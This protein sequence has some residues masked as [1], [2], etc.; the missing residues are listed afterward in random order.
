MRSCNLALWLNPEKIE[1]IDY[2]HRTD[3]CKVDR[4]TL[5]A[6]LPGLYAQLIVWDLGVL[7]DGDLSMES[8]SVL[9]TRAS[10]TFL[11]GDPPS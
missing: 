1:I 7:L 6:S 3:A 8:T 11:N 4:E 10:Q 2:G 5:M 9:Y